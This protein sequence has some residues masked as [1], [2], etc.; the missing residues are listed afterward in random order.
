MNNK[1][2]NKCVE[3]DKAPILKIGNQRLLKLIYTNVVSIKLFFINFGSAFEIL[4][5][6]Q[7]PTLRKE[8]LKN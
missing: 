6:I 2:N 4:K 5:T 3:P 8:L 7:I 1:V